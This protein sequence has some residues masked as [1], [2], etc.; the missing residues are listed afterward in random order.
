MDDL[1]IRGGY[2]IDPSQDLE[3]TLDVEIVGGR[4]RRVAPH[5]EP[6]G[7]RVLNA[8]GKIVTPGLV[9][10]HCHFYEGIT[11]YGVSLEA[12]ML[13]R[14]VTTAVDT[15]SAGAQTY[16]GFQKWFL[17]KAR[18]TVRAYLNISEGG[19]L[20]D[21]LGENVDMR[22]LRPDR[23]VACYE[24]NRK[25]L[26]G[27]K[28]RLSD[29]V[30]ERSGSRP[31]DAALEAAEFLKVPLMAHV[32]D[33]PSSLT[34]ILRR[35]RPGDVLTHAFH[36]RR[37]NILDKRGR[38]RRAVW[39]ARD[40]GVLLDVAHGRASFSFE[41]LE[42]A[43]EQGLMPG[44]L[45]TDLHAHCIHGPVY[46]FP[47][48][49]SKFLALGFPLAEVVRLS[50]QTAAEWI[51]LKGRV[52]TL[53]RGARG[54]AAVFRVKEG[55]F[56]FEDSLGARRAGSR[57]LETAQVVLGGRVVRPRRAGRGRK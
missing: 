17:E 41:I 8:A 23:A 31:L 39:E 29:N 54:D 22:A 32:G 19:L 20:I 51:G 14:G 43:M 4:V 50:T 53:K 40:A 38:V 10:L 30:V 16:P 21:G 56:A 42:K 5:V 12:A 57:M 27:M 36:G 48:L 37:E 26:I 35:L 34:A 55:R 15:G 49:M 33:T 1:V 3:G 45:S 11:H 24:K 2:V 28:V 46:D 44:N 13:A 9:D 25:Y 52:G 18:P 47:T 6:R 7:R